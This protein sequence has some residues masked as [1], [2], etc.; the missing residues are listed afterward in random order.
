MTGLKRGTVKLL[1]YQEE[2]AENAKNTIA[3]LRNILGDTAID[4]QHIG[5]T[6]VPHIH[7]KPIIDIAVGIR[8][9]DDIIPYRETLEKIIL[10][11]VERIFPD[12]CSLLSVIL[13]MISAPIISMLSCGKKVSGI[14]I[15]V[16]EII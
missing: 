10:F 15:Y 7:A 5:S 8:K 12:S 2:W 6:A 11:F 3:L 16:F 9:P 4:I 14:I 13:K 1:P